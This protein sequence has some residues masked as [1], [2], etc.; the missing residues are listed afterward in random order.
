[1]HF[2]LTFLRAIHPHSNGNNL[3]PLSCRTCSSTSPIELQAEVIQ[4]NDR[5]HASHLDRQIRQTTV[6]PA[7]LPSRTCRAVAGRPNTGTHT[8]THTH[9]GGIVLHVRI[10]GFCKMPCAGLVSSPLRHTPTVYDKTCRAI[11]V[12][13]SHTGLQ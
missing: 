2:T 10:R 12:Q 13:S 3:R 11:L 5:S 1:M 7:A 8:H 6:R 4:N 9:T